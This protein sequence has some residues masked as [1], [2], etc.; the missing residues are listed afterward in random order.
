MPDLRGVLQPPEPPAGHAPE[1][2]SLSDRNVQFIL[3]F[4]AQASSVNLIPHYSADNKSLSRFIFRGRNLTVDFQLRVFHY[5]IWISHLWIDCVIR[6]FTHIHKRVQSILQWLHYWEYPSFNQ[7][8]LLWQ[9][10][11]WY[12]YHSTF[13][14]SLSTFCI[15]RW[16]NCHGGY[17]LW[18]EATFW[19]YY[20]WYVM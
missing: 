10:Y 14:I 5:C 7:C 20:H 16:H 18:T 6:W 8:L 15:N 11:L 4:L 3:I 2:L 9:W 19:P 12:W 17:W 1:L 13:S